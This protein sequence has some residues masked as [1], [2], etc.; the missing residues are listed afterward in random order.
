MRQ[1]AIRRSE[2]HALPDFEQN[3][4]PLRN[5]PAEQQVMA[6]VAAGTQLLQHE[7]QE[8][9]YCGMP[10]LAGQLLAQQLSDGATQH[11]SHKSCQQ[12]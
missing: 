8:I 2:I 3:R 12:P 5:E 6:F 11:N 7:R 1:E 10:R 9:W 4:Q